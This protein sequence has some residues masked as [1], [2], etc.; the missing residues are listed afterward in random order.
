MH[1][2]PSSRALGRA[3]LAIAGGVCVEPPAFRFVPCRDTSRASSS[4]SSVH[5]VA[6]TD[7]GSRSAHTQGA[8]S[9]YSV[10]IINKFG[11]LM[12]HVDFL[13]SGKVSSNDYLRLAGTFHAL[14]T[15]SSSLS[16]VSNSR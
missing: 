15:I 1:H 2:S 10:L 6:M 3:R 4:C 7:T 9:I 14:H 16:P 5:F 11:S 13:R 12:F 8:P